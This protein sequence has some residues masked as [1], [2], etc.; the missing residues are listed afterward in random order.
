MNSARRS[1]K[2]KTVV[3]RRYHTQ[4]E[5]CEQAI[6]LLLVKAAGVTSTNGGEPKG[7]RNDRPAG[8]SIPE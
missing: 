8:P 1:P 4:D 7:S 5:A 3:Q 2:R 6:K